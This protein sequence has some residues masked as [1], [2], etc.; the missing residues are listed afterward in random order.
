MFI[1]IDC[2]IY[3]YICMNCICSADMFPPLIICII[4]CCCYCYYYICMAIIGFILPGIP[5]IP[6]IPGVMPGV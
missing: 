3:C 1:I 5:G 6:G 2:Y 4:Y